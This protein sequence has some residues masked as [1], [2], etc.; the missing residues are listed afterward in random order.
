MPGE[1][2]TF[3]VN[4]DNKSNRKIKPL[5]VTLVESIIFRATSKSKT[6][7]RNVALVDDTK[8]TEPLSN[9]EWNTG[10]ITVPPVCSSSNGLCGIIIVNYFLQLNVDPTG[11]SVSKDLM[12]P[13][14]IG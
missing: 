10:S 1:R 13:I 2:I 6:F 4:I 11:G 3:S 5:K 9:Y 8:F 12:I 7:H 14:T